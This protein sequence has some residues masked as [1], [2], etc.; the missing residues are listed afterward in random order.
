MPRD[1]LSLTKVIQRLIQK[2]LILGEL[3]CESNLNQIA[4]NMNKTL[5]KR[6]RSYL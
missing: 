1:S 2:Q 4:S 6:L 5:K 3:S